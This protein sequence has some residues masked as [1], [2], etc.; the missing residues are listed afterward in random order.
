MSPGFF[1]TQLRFAVRLRIVVEEGGT[2][3]ETKKG[4]CMK[5]WHVVVCGAT[6]LATSCVSVAS[7]RFRPC[8]N[9]GGHS[10][11]YALPSGHTTL[12]FVDNAHTKH[13]RNQKRGA[14]MDQEVLTEVPL[15]VMRGMLVIDRHVPA[16][17]Q[18]HWG[19]GYSMWVQEEFVCTGTKPPVYDLVRNTYRDLFF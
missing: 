18:W 14:F 10:E 15:L 1:F 9:L 13:E 12:I 4:V 2:I 8:V 7:G 19:D 3:Q 17:L 6:L 16:K 5:R 11:I